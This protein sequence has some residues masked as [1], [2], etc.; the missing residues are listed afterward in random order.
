MAT[1][2]GP[3]GMI[4]S[5]WIKRIMIAT[6]VLSVV[7]AFSIA[8]LSSSFPL[9]LPLTPNEFLH[10]SAVLPGIPALW[11][12]LTYP[13]FIMS[14][15]VTLLMAIAVYGW[16]G[17][18]LELTWGSARFLRF[19]AGGALVPAGLTVLLSLFWPSLSQFTVMGPAPVLEAMVIAWGLTFRDR[20]I[21]LF[22][23]LPIKGIYLV[24]FTVGYLILSILFSPSL[25]PFV[26]SI[27]GM[28]F[29]A[30][31]VLGAYRPRRLMLFYRKWSLERQIKSERAKRSARVAKAAHLRVADQDDDP[32][33]AAPSPKS[34]D[35]F[36]QG[37]PTGS[38]GYLN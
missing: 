19:F 13:F 25:Y 1:T 32:E 37:P 10:G 29:G 35:P 24:Y 3:L 22:M 11:Q 38:G 20:E 16:I 4:F 30:A 12:P 18:S 34:S 9:A 17:G 27:L 31:V 26:P 21:R 36:D 15:P 23:V 7:G 14:S 8:W 6:F 2:Q 33:D 5:P 28:L